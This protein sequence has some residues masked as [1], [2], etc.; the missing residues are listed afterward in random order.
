MQKVIFWVCLFIISANV[1]SQ[2]NKQNGTAVQTIPL[3]NF[4]DKKA[5][6]GL[7]I[8]IHYSS[9]GGVMSN[10][11]SSALGLKWGLN[12]G[13]IIE[14]ETRGIADDQYCN[15]DVSINAD[16]LIVKRDFEEA[17]NNYYPNGYLYTTFAPDNKPKELAIQPRFRE[18]Q[19][20]DYKQSVH[21]SED[22]E[23]DI[24]RFSLNGRTGSFIIG[25]NKIPVLLDYSGLKVSFEERNMYAADKIRTKI[26]S[27]TIIDENGFIYRFD[28]MGKNKVTK[29]SSESQQLS[30]DASISRSTNYAINE[31]VV[32]NWNLGSITN[33][34]TNES[35]TF[36]YDENYTENAIG[37]E[38][39]AQVSVSS[40]ANSVNRVEHTVMSCSFTKNFQ[41]KKQVREIILPGNRKFSFYYLQDVVRIDV[42]GEPPLRRIENIYAGKTIGFAEFS[43]KYFYKKQLIPLTNSI[44]DA[45]EKRFLRL[46]L[47]GI[48]TGGANDK[49]Y[50]ETQLEYFTGAEDADSKAIVPPRFTFSADDWGFYNASEYISETGNMEDFS[51]YGSNRWNLSTYQVMIMDKE[52][53]NILSNGGFT[54][55]TDILKLKDIKQGYAKFGLLRKIKNPN[56]GT[57]EYVYEQNKMPDRF[58]GGVR[59][60]KV[61][62]DDGM[63]NQYTTNYKYGYRD[64]VD[65]AE[66]PE[67][68][69]GYEP[70]KF[71]LLMNTVYNKTSDLLSTTWALESFKKAGIEDAVINSYER[72]KSL[73]YIAKAFENSRPRS[74]F[75]GFVSLG[76]NSIKLLSSGGHSTYNDY[77]PML[78]YIFSSL[79]FNWLNDIVNKKSINCSFQPINY[80]NSFGINYSSVTEWVNNGENG[81]TTEVYTGKQD[82]S[83]PGWQTA[84]FNFPYSNRQRYYEWEIGLPKTTE[85]YDKNWKLQKLEAYRYN[86]K[87]KQLDNNYKSASWGVAG[88]YSHRHDWYAYNTTQVQDYMVTGESYIYKV[89]K[90]FLEEKKVTTYGTDN[91]IAVQS[92]QYQYNALN[93]QLS[94]STTTDSKG[95]IL[96]SNTYYVTDY[97]LPGAIQV[98]KD[99][100]MLNTPVASISWKQQPGQAKKML[101]TSITNFGVIANGE[102]RQVQVFANKVQNMPVN[103]LVNN[104]NPANLANYPDIISQISN[105]YDSDGNLAQVNTP[106]RNP[107]SFIYNYDK[108]FLVAQVENAETGKS[109]YTSF[110]TYDHNKW[111]LNRCSPT[112]A[113]GITG[114]WSLRLNPGAS[115]T[116]SVPIG[117]TY[118]LSF[119][120]RG[121]NINVNSSTALT[122]KIQAPT[123]NGWT[124]MQYEIPANANSPVITGN[125]Y[126]DELRLY[127]KKS[128]MVTTV[129]DPAFG[130][131]TAL[132]DINN[133]IVYYQYDDFGRIV[134]ERNENYDVIKYYEYKYKNQ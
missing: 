123:I 45:S 99:K 17:F 73:E 13:G 77:V 132:C 119:W 106:D 63:D 109:A 9:G 118:T 11:Q 117:E 21:S 98:L 28:A 71:S 112:S 42:P 103:N 134:A 15:Y 55:N 43:Y 54:V 58:V 126:I 36:V 115:V 12:V 64:C 25:K 86:F 23:A 108:R 10:E 131:K 83:F 110:E 75:M 101:N 128:S 22:R 19:T 104:F 44:A 79:V 74:Q 127:P 24:F 31:Y 70:A 48:K 124:Y 95:H 107:T 66:P 8:S 84:P 81:Y 69:W 120:I 50:P 35:I 122:P 59:V 67:S 49:A 72:D 16:Y 113:Y 89:G 105:F 46:A 96:G 88:Y 114:N 38:P 76:Y 111:Q 26:R 1:Q 7:D 4:S 121:N 129:Y 18:S 125:C 92:T 61:I 3:F 29:G 6:L 90:S 33:P 97:T 53:P 56:G 5:G 116:T 20:K 47:C 93:N 102:V 32:N 60:S 2:V 27:F 94:S 130:Y 57:F 41:Y 82:M 100:N 52:N 37:Y 91:N 78:N 40:D 51:Y 62:A 80:K 39:T 30:S 85:Y 133:R 65:C 14:R 68:G 87:T 34:F